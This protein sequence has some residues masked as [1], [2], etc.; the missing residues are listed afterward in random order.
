MNPLKR[1]WLSIAASVAIAFLWVVVCTEFT[2]ESPTHAAEERPYQA[3]Y[4]VVILTYKTRDR[5]LKITQVDAVRI[6]G[7]AIIVETNNGK[8]TQI[9]HGYRKIERYLPGEWVPPVPKE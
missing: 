7:D 2:F 3:K 4:E 5:T 9:F 8:T 6:H 1:V